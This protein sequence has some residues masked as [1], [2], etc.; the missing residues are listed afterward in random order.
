M[1]TIIALLWT[2]GEKVLA[3][4]FGLSALALLLVVFAR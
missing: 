2:S 3:V 1:A 4:G